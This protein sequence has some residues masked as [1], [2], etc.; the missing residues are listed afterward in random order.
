VNIEEWVMPT[1]VAYRLGTRP[2]WRSLYDATYVRTPISQ[3]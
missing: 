1:M 2:R 3:P